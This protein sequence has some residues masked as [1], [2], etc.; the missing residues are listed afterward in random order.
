MTC[1]HNHDQILEFLQK[2]FLKGFQIYQNYLCPLSYDTA[3]MNSC[4]LKSCKT[5]IKVAQ[6]LVPWHM[7][8]QQFEPSRTKIMIHKISMASWLYQHKYIGP[9]YHTKTYFIEFY[10]L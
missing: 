4:I 10:R 5:K 6:N 8:M 3:V 7:H 9:M 2:I 1:L